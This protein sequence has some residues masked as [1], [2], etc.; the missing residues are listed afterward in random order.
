MQLETC[1]H[2]K[3]LGLLGK[4]LVD[5]INGA[6]PLSDHLLLDHRMGRYVRQEDVGFVLFH[7]IEQFHLW[8]DTPQVEGSYQSCLNRH[9]S[10]SCADSVLLLSGPHMWSLQEVND[11]Y[12]IQYI[13]TSQCNHSHTAHSHTSYIT[14]IHH[15][16]NRTEKT[17]LHQTVHVYTTLY[18]TSQHEV[19]H[20]C[21]FVPCL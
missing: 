20:L 2:K 9:E 12:S 19:C 3:G 18:I 17:D 13:Y 14:F 10:P 11:S 15:N 21:L 7:R 1:L 16:E 5:I 6:F 4:Y 8:K